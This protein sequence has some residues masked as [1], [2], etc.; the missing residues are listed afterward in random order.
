MKKRILPVLLLILPYLYLFSFNFGISDEKNTNLKMLFF[1][2]LW[3][4]LALVFLILNSIF[5]ALSVAHGGKSEFFL[6]WNMLLK[7]IHIPIYLMVFFVGTLCFVIPT[8]IIF[9]PFLTAFD[10]S[11]LILTSI[12]GIGGLVQALR[13]KKITK[14]AALVLGVLHFFFCADVVCAV[15]AFC[16]VKSKSKKSNNEFHQSPNEQTAK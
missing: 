3:V 8:S 12:Y 14:T 13:E 1:L 16:K 7:L 4:I 15:V 9:I 5:V 10:Y 2:I 11:L 6:F